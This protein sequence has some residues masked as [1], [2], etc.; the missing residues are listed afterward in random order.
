M[1]TCSKCKESK[2]LDSFGKRQ[3][4]LDG[5]QGRCRLCIKGYDKRDKLLRYWQTKRH[6]AGVVEFTVTEQY[7]R[8]LWTDKCPILGIPIALGKHQSEDGLAHLDRIDSS[9]GYIEGNVQ[10]LSAKANRIKSNGTP[11]EILKVYNY[12]KEITNEHTT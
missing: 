6:R 7:L 3:S 9:L 11:E 1:K 10:W 5:Y 12:L 8:K 2:P 4:S